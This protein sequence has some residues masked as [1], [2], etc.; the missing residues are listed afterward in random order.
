V[1]KVTL[2]PLY[3]RKE[4]LYPLSSRLSGPQNLCGCFREQIMSFLCRDSNLVLSSQLPSPCVWAN[5]VI[6]RLLWNPK[7]HNRVQN[8]LPIEGLLSQMKPVRSHAVFKKHRALACL[9]I[10]EGAWL[11]PFMVVCY[12]HSEFALRNMSV[13]GTVCLQWVICLLRIQ[14]ISTVEYVSRTQYVC[15][16]NMSAKDTVC[17]TV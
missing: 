10:S 17:C 8:N 11:R 1:V 5:K 6:L 12:G 3:P 4:P 14:C 7:I 15:T 13:K 16:V 9:Y 2:R